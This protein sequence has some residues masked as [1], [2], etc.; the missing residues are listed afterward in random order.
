MKKFIFF[1]YLF[2]FFYIGYSFVE[3]WLELDFLYTVR[4]SYCAPITFSYENSLVNPAIKDFNFNGFSEAEYQFY[5][6]ASFIDVNSY[7]HDERFITWIDELF[8]IL[9]KRDMWYRERILEIPEWHIC[10]TR[11]AFIGMIMYVCFVMPCFYL[12]Y[13]TF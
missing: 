11:R 4:N 3:Y 9:Y 10:L 7:I 6:K 12:F 5:T 8:V 2:I 13:I 1:I